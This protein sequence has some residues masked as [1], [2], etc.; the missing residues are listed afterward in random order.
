[1]VCSRVPPFARYE[2]LTRSVSNHST[3]WSANQLTSLTYTSGQTTLGDLTYAYDAAGRRTVVGGSWART[4]VPAPVTSAMYV[5]ANRITA[6]DGTTFTYD[7]NG[8]LTG[9][10]TTT[11]TWNARDQLAALSGGTSGS[12]QYDGLGRRRTKTI[13]GT[14][15]KFLYDGLNLVQELSSGGTPTA[16]LLTGL[17]IDE[18][19]TRTDS[20]G[21]STLITGALGSTI[22]LADAAGTLQTHYTYEPFGATTASGATSANAVQ[23]SGREN[24]GT[25]LYYYRARFYGPTMQR[26]VSEDRKGF[27]GGDINFYSYVSNSP[28]TFVDPSGLDQTIW[29]WG[30]NGRFG[31]RN[32][33][34][35]GG[36]WGGGR[37]PGRNGGNDGLLP[38][39]DS[40]DRCYMDHDRCY[41]RCKDWRSCDAQLTRCL[42]RLPWDPRHWPEP[43]RPGTETDSRLFLEF[44]RFIFGQTGSGLAV[45]W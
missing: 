23:F 45:T 41:E 20:N 3:P 16:N 31:P 35:G 38:P 44:A 26:F 15:T 34:W 25:G 2:I 5:A 4:G 11:S 10:G 43:P 30:S 19:F 9:D 21:T 8:N 40:A 28:I 7:L 18:I 13:G 42:D 33:N 6:W 14:T 27:S 24:D 29:D 36:N 17:G 1:M 12:F 32:G 22:E 39:T 37:V